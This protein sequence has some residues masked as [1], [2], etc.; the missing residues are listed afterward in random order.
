MR[1]KK[2]AETEVT[3]YQ[4][5]DEDKRES[6]TL[7]NESCLF[8]ILTQ[9][10]QC[11]IAICSDIYFFFSFVSFSL[12]ITFLSF[13]L[14]FC[15]LNLFYLLISTCLSCL[16]FFFLLPFFCPVKPS[17]SFIKKLH[18]HVLEFKIDSIFSGIIVFL[19]HSHEFY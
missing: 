19:Y 9:P 10:N 3:N 18:L 7:G 11:S 8:L 14:F 12:N 4:K 13:S 6:L 2:K 17:L 1:W 5:K 16:F 15:C